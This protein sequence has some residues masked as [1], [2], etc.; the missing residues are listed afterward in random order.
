LERGRFDVFRVLQR[1]YQPFM[2]MLRWQITT[3]ANFEKLAAMPPESLTDLERSACFIPSTPCLWRQGGR[4]QF[5]RNRW[6][7]CEL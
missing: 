1:H 5:W 2:D 3:R 7:L 4:S 6:P